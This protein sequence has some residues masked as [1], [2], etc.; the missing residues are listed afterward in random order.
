MEYVPETLYKVLKHYN[1]S[2][3]RMPLIYVKLYAYQVRNIFSFF[4]LFS[5]LFLGRDGIST[6]VHDKFQLH[7]RYFGGLAYILAFLGVCHRDVKPQ[8]LLVDPLT[9]QVNL[10]D[11][12]SVKALGRMREANRNSKSPPIPQE[13]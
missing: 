1:N 2:N 6:F 7:D 3:Q 8:N 11:F 5:P 13:D 12:R 4:F 10:C 9:H